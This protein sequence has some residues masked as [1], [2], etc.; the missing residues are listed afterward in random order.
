MEEIA[1]TKELLLKDMKL[2]KHIKRPPVNYNTLSLSK[3][4]I[5]LLTGA[6]GNLGPFLVEW[7]LMKRRRQTERIYCLVRGQNGRER[8]LERFKFLQVH[9]AIDLSKITVIEGK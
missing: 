5:F 4:G 9:E 7:L 6:T 8:M 3:L 1:R 2:P